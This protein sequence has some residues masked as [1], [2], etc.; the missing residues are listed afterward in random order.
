M[1][2]DEEDA[3]NLKMLTARGLLS[4]ESFFTDA[5]KSRVEFLCDSFLNDMWTM[6]PSTTSDAKFRRKV[7]MLNIMEKAVTLYLKLLQ[8][9]AVFNIVPVYRMTDFDKEFMQ[10]WGLVS[11]IDDS[12]IRRIVGLGLTPAI[13]MHYLFE[14]RAVVLVKGTVISMKAEDIDEAQRSGTQLRNELYDGRKNKL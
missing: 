12:D 3:Y 7:D 10:E 1:L 4:Y 6:Y 9:P 5:I 8:E 11:E 13:S 2:I 14:D